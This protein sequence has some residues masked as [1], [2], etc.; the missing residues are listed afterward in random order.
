MRLHARLLRRLAFTGMR[1][2]RDVPLGIAVVL[3]LA[4]RWFILAFRKV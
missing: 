4:V 3:A 1:L 2:R